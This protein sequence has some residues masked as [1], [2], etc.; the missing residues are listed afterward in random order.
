MKRALSLMLLLAVML[1]PAS[2][3]ATDSYSDEVSAKLQSGLTNTL[4]GWT[5][6]FSVPHQYQA[7]KKNPWAGVGKGAVDAVHCTV[8]GAF[9]LLTFPIPA[10]M[11]L[12]D[13][14]HILENK[15]F[16]VRYSGLG[17]VAD[18]AI[19]QPKVVALVLK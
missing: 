11:T 12:R 9:N 6:V 5:K 10:G 13:A 2:S 1:V 19:V 17:K 14:M 16:R 3:F 15:G 18:F 7:E 4:F 8:A